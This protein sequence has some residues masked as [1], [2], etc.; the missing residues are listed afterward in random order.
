M[1]GDE[2]RIFSK[3]SRWKPLF[4]LNIKIKIQ[5]AQ[6]RNTIQYSS[7]FVKIS[8]VIPDI[9]KPAL[10][11]NWENVIA[12]CEESKQSKALAN[13]FGLLQIQVGGLGSSATNFSIFTL[14][15]VWKYLFPA[16]KLTL[17]Y[18]INMNIS[19]LKTGNL[20]I[21]WVPGPHPPLSISYKHVSER[22]SSQFPNSL[23]HWEK[24]E[25]TTWGYIQ[26]SQC[27]IFFM[28]RE[29]LG[30]LARATFKNFHFYLFVEREELGSTAW[31]ED[32]KVPVLNNC[33]WIG[34]SYALVLS[35]T[36][37]N[38]MRNLQKAGHISY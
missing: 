26:K 10:T 37:E 6:K 13:N 33:W 28:N 34:K 27:S 19:L 38:K 25:S 21:Y 5:A 24:I 20:I 14:N 7:T 12:Y 23:V 16:L 29:K 15:L 22:L 9:K 30:S 32:P 2:R 31:D 36:F 8:G 35:F 3:A 4:V 17:N 18:S 11:N 1:E